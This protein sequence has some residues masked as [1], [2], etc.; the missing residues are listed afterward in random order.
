VRDD[1]AREIDRLTASAA[2]WKDS[3]ASQAF[4]YLE[5]QVESRGS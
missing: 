3:D 1:R 4:N 5:R 2:E